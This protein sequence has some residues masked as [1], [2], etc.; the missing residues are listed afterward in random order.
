MTSPETLKLTLPALVAIS[1]SATTAPSAEVSGATL[2]CDLLFADGRIVDGT[3]APWF[4]GDVCIAGGRITGVGHLA[5]ATAARRVD[6]TGLVLA[7]GFIDMLGQ[8][9][10]NVLVD[11]RAASKITQ[12]ITTEI[13]GEGDSIAPTSAALIAADKETWDYYGVT[14]DFMTLAGYWK[15][16]ERARPA[17]NLGTFVGA[18]G[19]RRLVVGEDDRAASPGE[20]RA[21]EQAVAQAME[22]GALGLSSSLIYTPGRF[23]STDEIIA[24]ARVA[25]GFG[26]SY[27]THQRDEGDDLTRIGIDK[28]LDEVF[29]IAREARIPAEI[30][31]LK[32]SGKAG[33][34]TMP[35]VIQRI[36]DARALGLDISADQYPWTA[37]S[38]ALSASVPAWAREG[39]REKLVARLQDPAIRARLLAEM[40]RDE[41]AW[42]GLAGDILITSVLNPSVKA[43]EGKTLA[44][45]AKDQGKDPL[46]AMFDLLVADRANTSRITFKMSEDDVRAALRQP[47]VS[48]CTDS[49]AGAEDGILS[50]QKSHPRGWASTARILGKYVRD[51]KV[52][53]LEEAVRK[54]TSL[55]AS[56]V[57]LADRGLLRPG[58]AA[59]LVAFDP[60]KVRER[61]TY[62]DPT[63]YSE[64]FAYVAVNGQL[65]VD[66]GRIT[67]AR[68]G[69]AIKGPGY[70]DR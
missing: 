60:A 50:R 23:A 28:S 61:S 29:R 67:P 9:E 27:I 32:V 66:E 2:R 6:A 45:I 33:W 1:L 12:G 35:R 65:V 70:R 54:M 18:G 7:P 37:S 24:L 40:P 56:R 4:R 34:G 13:T 10:Y 31:H 5:G 48:M 62:A 44:E 36:E 42:P 58:M 30:Y 21:M 55:P 53:T 20:L 43:L 46:T 59:D 17:I 15:A 57:R 19:V 68:P 25:A 26:G 38:N 49:G 51:E 11:G 22:E 64:G 41:P 47:W 16:F 52:L 39:G 14:P 69:R 8:S 3:G 63:H